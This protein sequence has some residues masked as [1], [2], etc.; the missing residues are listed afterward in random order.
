MKLY[1]TRVSM[2]TRLFS[3]LMIVLWPL[4]CTFIAGTKMDSPGGG[5]KVKSLIQSK[6][7]RGEC[8]SICMVVSRRQ[9]SGCSGVP[10]S[11]RSGHFY[12]CF[13]AS[14]KT[15]VGSAECYNLQPLGQAR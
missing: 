6:W 10:E 2:K 15:Y 1:N 4:S 8:C 5:M 13:S 11:G 14:T 9:P 12:R 7:V 3:Y